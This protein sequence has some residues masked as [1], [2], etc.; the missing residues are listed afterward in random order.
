MPAGRP[1]PAAQS[2]RRPP[3]PLP[4]L[5]LC[6]L[7]A[8]RAGSGAGEYR[9]PALPFPHG[10]KA[11]APGAAA[12]GGGAG[13]TW[14]AREQRKAPPAR[15]SGHPHLQGAR[16][17]SPRAEGPA[18]APEAFLPGPPGRGRPARG[19]L[20]PSA[21]WDEAGAR[22]SVRG[23]GVAETV[24]HRSRAGAHAV[25]ALGAGPERAPP[26]GGMSPARKAGREGGRSG[27][28]A[29]GPGSPG[30]RLSA[31]RR[32]RPPLAGP[33]AGVL[34]VPAT[35]NAQNRSGPRRAGLEASSETNLCERVGERETEQEPASPGTAGPSRE[36]G[37][38]TGNPQLGR[39]GPL[40]SREL[41]ASGTFRPP[42]R[43]TPPPAH[44][45]HIQTR[46]GTHPETHKDSHWLV[47]RHPHPQTC[48]HCIPDAHSHTI[49]AHT[50]IPSLTHIHSWSHTHSEG[51][52]TQGH[53]RRHS[54]PGTS[55]VP[56][57]TLSRCTGHLG[58]HTLCPRPT[59]T[60]RSWCRLLRC[61]SRKGR[62]RAP[63]GGTCQKPS[64]PDAPGQVR[65]CAGPSQV[66][67]SSARLW[68][69]PVNATVS[70][71]LFPSL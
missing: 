51:E 68:V 33:R 70:D 14:T 23:L 62:V 38:L 63:P 30:T 9:R 6:V 19:G 1:G 40:P 60:A 54:M 4:L 17:R 25:G 71:A 7:G 45:L 41:R 35:G 8:P 2:A 18:F 67:D 56:P 53:A 46:S 57:C 44:R 69:V 43:C 20:E 28:L 22:D 64:M 31:G 26:G 13:A 21:R 16:R 55:T 65:G 66:P 24:G 42:T 52:A 50:H 48:A 39:P 59:C 29:R 49:K 37:E 3:P 11:C 32:R 61:S 34:G 10:L 36:W 27:R 47:A 15:P 58:G 5:L 12:G